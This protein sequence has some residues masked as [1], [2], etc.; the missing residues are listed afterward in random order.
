M[1]NY[2]KI[3]YE[4]HKEKIKKRTLEYYY[5]NKEKR[6][7]QINDWSKQNRDKVRGY[8][9]KWKDNNYKK[10]SVEQIALRKIKIDD[11]SKCLNCNTN[12]N[13]ERHH[14]DYDEPLEVEILCRVYHK[15]VHRKWKKI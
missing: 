5:K 12:S 4:R 11:S 3:K 8:I 1:K 9:Q 6:L 14:N 13:L 10:T 15:G 7:E 2:D